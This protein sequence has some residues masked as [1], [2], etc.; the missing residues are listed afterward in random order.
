MNDNTAF[1][2][3]IYNNNLFVWGNGP[4]ELGGIAVEYL[5]KPLGDNRLLRVLDLGCGYGRDSI[6]LSQ[7]L[8]CEVCGIDAS[9]EAIRM[10]QKLAAGIGG[11]DLRC[12]D[13]MRLD[14]GSYDA[15]FVS[16]I[17]HFFNREERRMFRHIVKS[18]LDK[19][20]LLFL[21]TLAIGDP[22]DYGRG[23]PVSDD[24]GSFVDRLYL[25]FSTRDELVEEFSFVNIRE[26]YKLEYDEPHSNGEVHHHI[27]WIL[28]GELAATC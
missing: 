27:S 16:N 20:G 21:S 22:Q 1:W 9:G 26:L 28:I 6:Y 5:R 8:G 18:H 14:E 13:F 2:D 11:V 10:G 17:Y 24:P 23:T 7:S 4:S 25:H 3:N 15:V 12:C 19:S